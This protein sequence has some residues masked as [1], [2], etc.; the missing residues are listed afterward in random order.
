MLGERL[1]ESEIIKAAELVAKTDV[2]SVYHFMVNVP[3][4]TEA[5][6]AKG[7]RLLE[8]LYKIHGAKRNLGTVV[9]NNI[10]ILPGTLIESIARAEGVISGTTD[11]LY[12]VYYNPPPFESLR[13]R[14]ETLHF[15][16][17]IFQWQEIT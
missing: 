9:L 12:P 2:V 5:T 16:R 15:C 10:R 1:R 4:E 11:L 13:Y 6:V 3:G 14:L 17:N 7:I 8:R